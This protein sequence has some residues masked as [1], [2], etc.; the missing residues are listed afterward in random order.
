MTTPRDS[1]REDERKRLDLAL[2]RELEATFPAS[3][4]L[5]IT[6]PGRKSP[7]AGEQKRSKMT[8]APRV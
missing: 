6:R 4:P 5:K 3:D 2:D 8:S 7:S 1:K